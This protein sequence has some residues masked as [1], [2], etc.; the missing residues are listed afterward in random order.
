MVNSNFSKNFQELRKN[1]IA[2]LSIRNLSK[3]AEK[4]KKKNEDNM[5]FKPKVNNK[6]NDTILFMKKIPTYEEQELLRRKTLEKLKKL[7]EQAEFEQCTFQPTIN[8]KK[9]NDDLM[10]NSPAHDR[11]Y[12]KAMNL[13]RK[14]ND[15]IEEQKILD[16]KKELKPCLFRPKINKI[17]P[18]RLNR[19]FTMVKKPKGYGKFVET[20]R[21]GIL[22][23]FQKKYLMEQKPVGENYEKIKRMNIQPFN[24]TDMRKYKENQKK[25][26]Y[27]RTHKNKKIPNK[28]NSDYVEEDYFTIEILVQNGKKR[29]IKIYPN[30]DPK[31]ITEEFCK[32]YQIKD[33]IKKKLYHNICNFKQQYLKNK[34]EEE[35][36]ED[37]EGGEGEEETGEG[38]G[39][40]EGGGNDNIEAYEGEEQNYGQER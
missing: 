18:D 25:K 14:R 28:T 2:Y 8:Q 19:S 23:R 27:E 13:I 29:M 5:S 6:T 35:D 26:I 9:F 22:E 11:L 17:D 15:K 24:I 39:E 33:D 31:E 7:K 10:D 32:T 12:K 16:Q 37:E 3:N 34:E 21:K 38:E 30:D 4:D 36:E 20:H 1:R 40:E